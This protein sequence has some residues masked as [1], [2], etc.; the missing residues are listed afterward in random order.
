MYQTQFECFKLLSGEYIVL[1]SKSIL[2]TDRS[3]III[4]ELK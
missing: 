4:L 2:L 3:V 1:N